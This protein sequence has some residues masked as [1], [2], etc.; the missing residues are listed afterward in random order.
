MPWA[1][2]ASA[3]AVYEYVRA[4]LAHFVVFH[5]PMDARLF[6][7]A[8]GKQEWGWT[9]QLPHCQADETEPNTASFSTS[10]GGRQEEK[11]FDEEE[12]AAGALPGGH[13]AGI[14]AS[15]RS[16]WKAEEQEGKGDPTLPFQLVVVDLMDST[17]DKSS[18]LHDLESDAAISI[19]HRRRR[20]AGRSGYLPGAGARQGAQRLPV[21]DRDRE[22][23]PGHQQQSQPFQKLHFRYAEVGVNTF[24]YVGVADC[25]RQ[26]Q[27][28]E[29]PGARAGAVR[30][31]PGPRRRPGCAV[32]FLDLIRLHDACGAG[33]RRSA[34]KWQKSLQPRNANWLR[35]KIGRMSG[36]K[37]APWSSRPSATACMAWWPAAPAPASPSC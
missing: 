26:P 35:C 24:R 21:G 5:A 23:H 37:P 29:G 9:D 19:L 7:L 28:H 6:V 8:A 10:Q 4:M 15:A 14:L 13:P 16:N 27:Q 1:S 18:P 33:G 36:N 32:P 2:P 25:D 22:N 31:A 11:P 17:Y 12:E 3:P 30:G 34:R 20:F